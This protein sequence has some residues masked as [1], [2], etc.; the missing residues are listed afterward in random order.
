[1]IAGAKLENGK[2]LT[3]GGRVLGAIGRGESLE[4]SIKRA[5]ENAEKIHFEG[6]YKRSDIGQRAL[7]KLK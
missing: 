3:A 6:A 1:M 5:Y 4:E 7:L 2:L